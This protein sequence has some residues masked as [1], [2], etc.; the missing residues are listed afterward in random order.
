MGVIRNI[1]KE[2][3][4]FFERPKKKTDKRDSLSQIYY[5]L[6]LEWID[7]KHCE[8]IK[9]GNEE[10]KLSKQDI[11]TASLFVWNYKTIEFNQHFQRTKQIQQVFRSLQTEDLI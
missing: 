4:K 2:R 8:K 11:G 5:A 6:P 1:P 9:D 7:N 10:I 3:E